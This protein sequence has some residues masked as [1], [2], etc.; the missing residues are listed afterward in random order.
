MKIGINASFLRKSDTGIGQVTRGFIE[1][2][3]KSHPEDNE[4][5]LY[6]ENDIDL[7]LPKNFRKRISLPKIYG[8]DDLI[9]KIWWE[10]LLLPRMAARDKCE[11]FISLYQSPTIL[12]GIRHKMLVHDMVWKIFPEYL[13]NWRK[14]FYASLIWRGVKKADEIFA[15]SE[16]T[17]RD[18]HKYLKI[19]AQSIKVS[20]P[21]ISAEF[22]GEK[23]PQSD[24]KILDK[25][26]IYGRYVFYVG[27]FD[28]RKNI[29]DLLAAFREMLS[30]YQFG[31][32][33]LVLAGDDKSKFS[34]LFSDL[35]KEIKT[36]D[37][38][39]KVILAG[40]VQQKDLPALY[41]NCDLF[42]FPSIYEGFGLPVLEAMT[43]GAPAAVSKSS[44]LP[45]V[46]GNAV[47]YF[48]SHDTEE[49]ARVMAKVLKNG[50][51]RRSLS[52]KAE[53]RSKRFSWDAFNKNII[54]C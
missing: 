35:K 48:N 52:E 42:V 13:D 36:A 43:S 28:F 15:V 53:A 50:K 21:S 14:K 4:Y 16:W 49:M 41:R 54:G 39:D 45:E 24:N 37:L 25:Y 26:D 2:L 38:K 3:I 44:S 46:G 8:R 18:I 11:L 29:P 47:L 33:K 40:F 51:L 17:K 30:R 5:F 7:D 22:A 34:P 27:G 32:I 23:D 12:K 19:K 31:D 20:Y 9:R 1:N 10:K 6:L